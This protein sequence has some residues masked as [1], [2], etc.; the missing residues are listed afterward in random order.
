MPWHRIYLEYFEDIARENLRQLG[1]K[2]ADNWA[3]PYWD[4]L[5]EN[6]LVIPEKFRDPLSPLYTQYRNPELNEGKSIQDLTNDPGILPPSKRW[7]ELTY[8]ALYSNSFLSVNSKIESMPHDAFHVLAGTDGNLFGRDGLLLTFEG[9][10]FD[11]AFWV[12]HAFIDKLWS[13]Y[14]ASENAYY[15]YESDLDKNKMNYMFLRPSQDGSIDKEV[16]S[17]WGANSPKVIGK[18]YNP[19]YGYDYLVKDDVLQGDKGPNKVL[20][21]IQSSAFRPTVYQ[22]SLAGSKLSPLDNVY[23]TVLPFGDDITLNNYRAL[24][25]PGKVFR[26]SFVSDISLSLSEPPANVRFILTTANGV[27]EI[28]AGKVDPS[29]FGFVIQRG[30]VGLSMQHHE[31]MTEH[32]VI[33]WSYENYSYIP[34]ADDGNQ[35]LLYLH[36]RIPLKRFCIHKRSQLIKI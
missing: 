17:Y 1:E 35:N 9:A 3:L 34:A 20:S 12:H 23:F 25:T 6:Q 28:R 31:H 7:S 16:I 4:Y 13:E 27:D 22:Q 24:T 14:N 2:S 5:N 19:N 8:P 26:F 21:I 15:V 10:G 30:M 36:W 29:L 11:P 33:D 32:A 18:I